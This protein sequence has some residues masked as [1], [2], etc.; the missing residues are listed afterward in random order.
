MITARGLRPIRLDPEE[1]DRWGEQIESLLL[2]MLEPTLP[3]F[4][5]ADD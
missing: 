2:P 4:P 1:R 5:T 3:L